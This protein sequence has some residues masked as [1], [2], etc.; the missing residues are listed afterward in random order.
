MTISVV[1]VDDESL[2]ASSLSSLL[3]LEDDLSV[4]ATLGSGEELLDWVANH[5]TGS[6]NVAV[7]DLQMG[8]IDGVEAAA[9]LQDGEDPPTVLIVTSHGRPR[10][11]K[12][13]MA[14]GVLGFVPKT[15]SAE[16][17]A[18]GGPHRP[19]RTPLSG[20]ELAAAAIRAGESPLTER[21]TEVLEVAGQG[22][23]VEQIAASV[24]L[25]AGTTRNYLSSAMAKT[26]ASTRFEAWRLAR[27]RGWL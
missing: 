8:G 13:A 26:G 24:H 11:L 2:V 3:D 4:V 12:R 9:Q 22:G 1:V 6:V 14:N 17:F 15:S 27:E 20:P 23:S 16:E 19:C 7:T 10:Q 21:E 5:S 25:A 18:H